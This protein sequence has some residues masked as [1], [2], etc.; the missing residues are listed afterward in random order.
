MSA[1]T[2]KSTTAMSAKDRSSRSR[3]ASTSSGTPAASSTP[4]R[5]GRFS[6][7]RHCEERS[8]EAI[9]SCCVTLDCFASLAMTMKLSIILHPRQLVGVEVAVAEQFLADPGALHEEADV[10]LVGHAHAAMHLHAFLHGERRGRAG[11]RFCHCDRASRL[12]EIA[13]ERLQRLQHGGAGDLDLDVELRGAMLQRLEFA[14]QLAE[15]LALLEVI[16]GAAEH[17]LRQ[18]DHFSCHRATADI[19]HTLEQR[20]ALIDLAEHAIGIDLGIVEHDP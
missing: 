20:P 9:Q 3:A 15:L 4:R 8:D 13:I 5:S 18:T 14:D 7:Q 16:D 6:P 2:A 17:F 1:I 19:Q 12:V 11:A 10:E